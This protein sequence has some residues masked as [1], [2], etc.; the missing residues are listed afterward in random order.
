MCVVSMIGDHF[1]QKWGTGGNQ[2]N[3]PNNN[4]LSAANGFVS[5][6]EFDALKREVEEMKEL[7][8]R[9]KEYDERT[10]QKDCEQDEKLRKLREIARLVGVDLD[11]IFQPKVSS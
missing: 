7:L 3:V 2:F 1:S 8:R 5:K 6:Y 9:A 4:G 10:G 11:E